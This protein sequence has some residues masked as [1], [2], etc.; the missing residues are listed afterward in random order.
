[1]AFLQRESDPTEDCMSLKDQLL[2]EIEASELTVNA[3]ANAAGIPVPVLH[4]FAKG[5]RGLTLDTVEK[6][7]KYFNLR[8]VQ[9]PPGPP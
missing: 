6:L 5:E 8:L 4:R 7:A 1:M 3:I 9:D 2:A